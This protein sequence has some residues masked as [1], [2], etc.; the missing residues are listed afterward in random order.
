MDGCFDGKNRKL[1][2]QESSLLKQPAR[3]LCTYTCLLL[4]MSV[5]LRLAGNEHFPMSTVAVWKAVWLWSCV[6]VPL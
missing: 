6:H 2:K 3:W 4:C 1:S 5:C